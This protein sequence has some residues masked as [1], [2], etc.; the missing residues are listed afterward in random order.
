MDGNGN[1]GDS[2]NTGRAATD[3]A[4]TAATT[5]D[6]NGGDH[7]NS[8]GQVKTT[9]AATAA[10]ATRA[11]ATATVHK[12]GW[13]SSERWLDKVSVR[14]LGGVLHNCDLELVTWSLELVA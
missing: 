1:A 3:A 7:G 12:W 4:A 6:A 5:T 10:T 8:D 11:T 2:D 9:A 14:L 13:R